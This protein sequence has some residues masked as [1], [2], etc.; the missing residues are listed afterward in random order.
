MIALAGFAI[1]VAATCAIEAIGIEFTTD[2]RL[3]CTA[4]LTQTIEVG[5]Q[6]LMKHRGFHFFT[7]RSCLVTDSD[8][9]W[10]KIAP[11]LTATII[12]ARTSYGRDFAA[13]EA[14]RVLKI[15][16][17]TLKGWIINRFILALVAIGIGNTRRHRSIGRVAWSPA[18]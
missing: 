11:I 4:I 18:R 15:F 8:G 7:V 16:H 17:Q 2:G 3:T 14:L 13:T 12:N 10:S 1:D 9:A 6:K 5:V